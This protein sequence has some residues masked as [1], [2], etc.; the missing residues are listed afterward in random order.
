MLESGKGQWAVIKYVLGWLVDGATRCIELVRERKIVI[1][2][3]LHNIVRMTTR[4]PFK[5]NKKMIR[6][7]RHAAT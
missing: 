6:K 4:V 1:D 5:R 2:A 3:Y 7:I